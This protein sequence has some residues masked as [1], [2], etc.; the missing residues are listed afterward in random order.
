MKNSSQLKGRDTLT[1]PMIVDV[2]D[3]L[4]GQIGFQKT[5]I[6]DIAQV[7]RMSPANI[8]RFFTSKA[9]INEAVGR[10][11]LSEIEVAIEQSA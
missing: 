9:E 8:Y 7:L 2:A 5:T 10:R 4:F 3:R 1:H 6:A 11:L